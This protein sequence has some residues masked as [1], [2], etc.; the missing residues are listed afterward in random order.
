M[1]QA[2]S[3]GRAAAAVDRFDP[4]DFPAEVTRQTT[5]GEGGHRRAGIK[6]LAGRSRELKGS[7]G[8]RFLR[9]HRR[10]AGVGSSREKPN[11]DWL[12]PIAPS[13]PLPPAVVPDRARL[14]PTQIRPTLPDGLPE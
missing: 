12:T 8:H 6:Q 2:M 13:A 3:H 14:A 1:L 7:E 9:Q 4:L 11:S 5:V 10:T